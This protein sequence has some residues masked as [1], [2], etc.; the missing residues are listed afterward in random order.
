MPFRF[1]QSVKSR[2]D[3]VVG[4]LLAARTTKSG[5]ATVSG[6]DAFQTFWADKQIIP[7]KRSSTDKYF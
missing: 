2:F 4:G 3:P 1:G 6:F 7:E 5:L